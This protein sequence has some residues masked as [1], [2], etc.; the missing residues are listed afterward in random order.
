M[1]VTKVELAGYE[2]V[3]VQRVGNVVRVE[4]NTDA[5]TFIVDM[6]PDEARVLG[7]AVLASSNI[8]NQGAYDARAGRDELKPEAP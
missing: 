7:A 4:V 1:H 5:I 2:S 3:E 8:P 6:L